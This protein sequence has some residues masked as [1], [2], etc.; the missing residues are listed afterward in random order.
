MDH[1]GEERRSVYAAPNYLMRALVC[2]CDVA[3]HALTRVQLGGV[4]ARGEGGD[5]VLARL[6]LE[7]G[8]IYGGAE[9]A[10]RRARLESHQRYAELREGRGQPFG[11]EHSVRTG[12]GVYV[13]D[14]AESA[15]VRSGGDYHGARAHVSAGAARYAAHAHS[16]AGGAFD[17]DGGDLRLHKGE[18]FLSFERVLHKE[19][20]CGAV[21]LHPL[22]A[23]RRAASGVERAAL[24]GH[25]VRRVAHF[26]AERVELEDEVTLSASPD[27]GIA[28]HI[29]DRVERY[30]EHRAR[31]PAASAGESRLDSGVTRADDDYVKAVFHLRDTLPLY[32]SCYFTD[33]VYHIP[34]ENAMQDT[35]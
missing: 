27:G 23:H 35:V 2:I 16:A 17:L 31:E 15:E 20:V 7:H 11:G 30:C 1:A 22:R 32:R 5:A 18:I 13:S 29:S 4:G 8:E 6:K 12:A 19:A 26:A 28:R 33:K 9:N 25:A 10:R 14:V 21:R 3:R 34:T 24:H